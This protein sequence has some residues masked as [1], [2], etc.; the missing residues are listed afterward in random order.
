MAFRGLFIGIDRYQS[1]IKWLS[2]ASRDAMALYALFSDTLGDGATLLIDQ[3]AT[4]QAIRTELSLLATCDK[5]DVVVIGFSGHGTPSHQ[6]VAYDTQRT[7]IDGTSIPLDE[8][9]EYFRQIPARHVV[10][11]LDCCFSG[12]MG[13]KVLQVD[14]QSRNI[15][16]TDE[17][18]NQMSGEGR[19]I[20]TAAQASE[21]AWEINRLN[22]GLL[23]YYLLEALQGA[24]EVREA[25]KVSVY[26]L[27]EYVTRRVVDN[28][29][30]IGKQQRPGLRGTI[31]G[32]LTWPIFTP[33]EKYR[34]L[35]PERFKAQ[36]THDLDS[37]LSH[38]FPAELIHIWG[39]AIPSLNQMQIDAI[40][41]YGIL[42]GNDL[43]VSAPTSSGKT[44]I[45][46][47]AALRGTLERK[48]A[49]FLLP[50]KALVNDKARYFNSLYGKYGIRTIEATG[51]T[52]DITPLIQG[53]YDICLLT[54]EKFASVALT[55]PYVLEQVSTVI[56]D[57]VQ[58]IADPSR[59]ANLE[60]ILTLLKMR[61]EQ[62]VAPQMILLS[63]VIG[64]TNG[65]ERW[66]N[67]RLLKREERPVPLEEGILRA[68]E[69]FRYLDAGTGEEKITES[70]IQRL[71]RKDSSQDWVIPLAHKLVSE[72]KKVIVFR[73]T[74]SEARNVAKY[75]AEALALPSCKTALDNLPQDDPVSVSQD[76][77]QVLE[78]G[79]AFHISDLTR[80]ERRVL[81]E[82][83]NRPNTNLR[84]IVATTTL[85]M[86]VNTPADAVV[87]VGL[88]H[89]GPMGSSTPYSVAEYK[90][91]VGRAGRLGY[92]NKGTSYLL[93][94]TPAD[95]YRMWKHYVRGV[96]ESIESRFITKDTDPRSLLLRVLV[97]T[98]HIIK[99]GIKA[100]DLI[101]FLESSFGAY[102]QKYLTQDWQWNRDVLKRALAELVGHKLVSENHLGYYELM[103]LGRIAGEA[104]IE[105]ESVIRLIDCLQVLNPGSINDPTL[106]SAA[107]LTVE[108]DNVL[109][110]INRKSTNKEPTAWSSELKNQGVPNYLLQYLTR[111]TSDQ[112]QPTLRAKKAVACLLYVT[113]KPL[114]EIENLLTR[115]GGALGGASGAIQ[116][117][118]S[119]VCDVLP[120]VCRIA[121][122][123]H[124]GLE[125]GDRLQRLLIRL[126]LGVPAVAVG[127]ASK[128]GN[129]L[130][131]GDYLRLCEL[132]LC[133]INAIE[134]TSDEV[135][136]SYFDNNVVKVEIIRKAIK[137]YREAQQEI[138][139]SSPILEPYVG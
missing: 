1:N 80:E 109:F 47:L 93:A 28:A 46:E 72:G 128:A 49:L 71:Y 114:L 45:G 73:E 57:E 55:N 25:G 62:G 5:D 135:L 70:V 103:P 39:N 98:G 13:A 120:I 41:E 119:R 92:S 95:E 50:L 139:I 115:F 132:G 2:C 131:R 11:F 27:L 118:T 32:D 15:L 107:Q 56:V 29:A 124:P 23:T 64:D 19:L 30:Q 36:V 87:I 66:L 58:M 14:A 85:A 106:L 81:E 99:T 44:L 24:E 123:I 26:S 86:G 138:V 83:F 51:E 121:E 53:Q 33:G 67:A 112:H 110:P 65:L 91:M 116:S 74:R 40:N 104:V 34:K 17:L 52:H 94:R 59:G 84:V 69:S 129:A 97:A 60:F 102:Q 18:L 88:D 117:T 31:D 122:T 127:L 96:P 61:R 101:R 126:S 22:H 130:T 37:L 3:Q 4:A 48:R 82:E 136:S 137:R 134:E 63:A 16:T 43:V 111:W 75:L 77:R 8:L 42:D 108:V 10:C 125:L 100:D 105:V 133:D 76:L 38:G 35:F 20:F 78:A 12:G 68:D 89:P 79:I 54:Y 21:P 9:T 7:D 6:I 90:N 113:Q